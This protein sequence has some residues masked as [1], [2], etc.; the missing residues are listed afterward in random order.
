ML[1]GALVAAALVVL[2][3]HARAEILVRWRQLAGFMGW[4]RADA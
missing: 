1:S 2:L 4:M 3:P